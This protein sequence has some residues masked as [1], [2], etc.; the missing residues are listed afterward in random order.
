MQR[1][2]GAGSAPKP[3]G[4]LFRSPQSTKG[5]QVPTSKAREAH[6][7]ELSV[8]EPE[9]CGLHF[10]NDACSGR[11][12]G[13]D[14][15]EGSLGPWTLW[16]RPPPL[17]LARGSSINR[18]LKANPTL[19]SRESG[20]RSRTWVGAPPARLAGPVPSGVG[21]LHDP[22]TLNLPALLSSESSGQPERHWPP[23][24]PALTP[25]ARGAHGRQTKSQELQAPGLSAPTQFYWG[26]EW[27]GQVADRGVKTAV[28]DRP[29]P[30]L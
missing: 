15:Q 16:N 23:V 8:N 19:S 20:L 12:G 29:A 21:G 1:G 13:E 28:A 5:R 11:A 4:F 17:P 14:R 6:C 10:H 2:G 27:G 7:V 9:A 3:H 24:W 25:G 30:L 18:P 22:L 26:G